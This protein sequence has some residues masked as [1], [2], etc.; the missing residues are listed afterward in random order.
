MRSTFGLMR[1]SAA[2][3]AA[4]VL[5][6]CG[7]ESPFEPSPVPEARA[8]VDGVA[9]AMAPQPKVTLCHKGETITVAQPAVQAHLDHGD[10]LG[11]CGPTP[12]P[13]ASPSPSPSPSASPGTSSCSGPGPGYWANWRNHYTEEQF[14]MLLIGTIALDTT[15]ANIYLTSVGC[16]GGDALACM[17]RSLLVA[18]LSINLALHP[19]LP[20]AQNASLTPTCTAPGVTGSLDFWISRA[21]AILMDPDSFTREEILEVKDAL[22]A[23]GE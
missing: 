3:A 4:L 2:L 9:V 14:A 21:K 19:E 10:K 6:A 22:A 11:A 5:S 8:S 16:D 13:S 12:S 7:A 23:F 20:N 18:Q 1:G 17:R 15:T